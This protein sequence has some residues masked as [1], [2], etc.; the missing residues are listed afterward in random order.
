MR[1]T[2]EVIRAVRDHGEAT[3]PEECCGFFLGRMDPAA[4][5]AHIHE[6]TGTY[7][8]P[9]RH[10]DQRERRFTL[11]PADYLAAEREAARLGL[12][13]VGVYHSHPDHP[14]R[15]SETDLAEAAFPGLAYVIVSV[16][17]GRAGE[18]TAWLLE[19]DR[20]RFNPDSIEHIITRSQAS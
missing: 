8:V 11:E 14:A 12:D 18:P 16:E 13:V 20:S 2:K 6:V 15:P 3:Y 17:Q 7:R 5:D 19:S 9:N 1:T 10:R 4:P